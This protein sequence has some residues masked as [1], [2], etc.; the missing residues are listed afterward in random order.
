MVHF[1][2]FVN[3]IFLSVLYIVVLNIFRCTTNI[4]FVNIKCQRDKQRQ[5]SGM[6]RQCGRENVKVGDM[7][8]RNSEEKR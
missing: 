5:R 3:G 8:M 1:C 6:E 2:K 7:R 4:Q